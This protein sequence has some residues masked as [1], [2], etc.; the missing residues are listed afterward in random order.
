MFCD[1]VVI[2]RILQNSGNPNAKLMIL[3]SVVIKVVLIRLNELSDVP[4]EGCKERSL[5][6]LGGNRAAY[7]GVKKCFWPR[8][9][10]LFRKMRF[11]RLWIRI[12]YYAVVGVI[13]A[14]TSLDVV[15][16]A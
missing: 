9:G 1:R 12:R 2:H 6:V 16:D 5:G 11:R 3:Q 13:I 8:R 4:N 10:T 14:E 15:F 7:S